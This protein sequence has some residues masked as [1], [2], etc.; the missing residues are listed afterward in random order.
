MDAQL[1]SLLV[2]LETRT[3]QLVLAYNQL[4]VECNGL[5]QELEDAEQEQSRLREENEQ[6]RRQYDHLKMAKYIEL[7]DDDKRLNRQRINKLVRE[8]DKCI[9]MLKSTTSDEINE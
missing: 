2:R 1:K 6:L 9:A 3:R 4:A 5:R 8:V 7:C